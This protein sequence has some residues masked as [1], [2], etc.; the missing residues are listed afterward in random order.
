ML[1]VNTFTFN[2]EG[3]YLLSERTN[4]SYEPV[5]TYVERHKKYPNT[6]LI[7]KTASSAVLKQR[8]EDNN[9]YDIIVVSQLTDSRIC[10]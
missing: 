5:D 9:Y 10:E 2:S 7:D 8:S 4:Y 3:N 1:K 6:L